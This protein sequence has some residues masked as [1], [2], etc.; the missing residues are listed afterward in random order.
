M[1]DITHGLLQKAKRDANEI[2]WKI[3]PGGMG[4]RAWTNE[5]GQWSFVAE[6]RHK[7][8]A[9]DFLVSKLTQEER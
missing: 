6:F 1:A 2:P 9:E 5:T 3:C 8:D 7:T 4:F